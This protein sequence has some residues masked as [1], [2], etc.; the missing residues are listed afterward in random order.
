MKPYI[1]SLQEAGY[2]VASSES[3]RGD[4]LTLRN[5]NANVWE[6]VKHAR[7]DAKVGTVAALSDMIDYCVKRIEEELC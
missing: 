4:L 1:D 2:D 6:C 3:L 5:A 7:G